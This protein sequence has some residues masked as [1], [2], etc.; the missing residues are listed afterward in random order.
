MEKSAVTNM[1]LLVL[2][3]HVFFTLPYPSRETFFVLRDHHSLS[4]FTEKINARNQSPVEMSSD[5]RS[6]KCINCMTWIFNANG[7]Y[8]GSVADPAIAKFAPFENVEPSDSRY[9]LR[10]LVFTL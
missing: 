9:G 4:N 2:N 3:S 8:L 7:T 10:R 1:R 5:E 6:L